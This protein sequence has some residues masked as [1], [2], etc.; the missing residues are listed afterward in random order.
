MRKSHGNKVT[1]THFFTPKSFKDFDLLEAKIKSI[2]RSRKKMGDLWNRIDF[3]GNNIVSLAE[4]DK[5]AVE[6]FPILNHKPALMR[7]YKATIKAGNGDD[8]VEKKEFKS[9]LGNLIYFN[10]IF[11]LFDNNDADKDRRLNE[12]EFKWMLMALGEKMSDQQA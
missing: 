1:H 3:N 4:I 10:K 12:K 6:A 9:L 2:M 7:A 8:W 11:W 5:L